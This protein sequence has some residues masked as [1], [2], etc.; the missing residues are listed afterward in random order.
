MTTLPSQT[1]LLFT[2]RIPLRWADMDAYGHINNVQ[3]L[4]LLEQSRVEWMGNSTDHPEWGENVAIVSVHLDCDFHLQISY[5][6]VAEIQVHLV[7]IG[8]SSV[9]IKQVLRIVGDE[10]VRA[11]GNAVLVFT[12]MATGTSVPVPQTARHLFEPR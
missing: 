11:E 1:V 8:R 12:N 7:K 6:G 10:R 5:P 3:Y 4:R 9:T 2:S